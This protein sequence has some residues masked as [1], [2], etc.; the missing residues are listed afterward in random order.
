[1]STAEHA[2]LV[3]L[4]LSDEEFG[5]ES[6]RDRITSLEERLESILTAKG[7]GEFDGSEVGMGTCTLY[8]Y[9]QDADLLF[10]AIE[11]TLREGSWPSGSYA[12]K[13][14]GPAQDPNSKEV[15]IPL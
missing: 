10:E 5:E 13:R 3:H 12:V 8:I 14:Y 9:G 4:R 6:E 7:V 1:M 11:S 15:R 2:V